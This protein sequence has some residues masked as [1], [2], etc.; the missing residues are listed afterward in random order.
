MAQNKYTVK[1]GGKTKTIVKKSPFKKKLL[2]KHKYLGRRLRENDAMYYSAAGVL[3]YRIRAKGQVEIFMGIEDMYDKVKKKWRKNQI[4][5]LGGKRER[6][7]MSPKNTGVREFWEESGGLLGP[8]QTTR[9]M[10]GLD[11]VLWFNGGKYA[12]YLYPVDSQ[13]AKY[14][15]Q[16]PSMYADA[17]KKGKL[18]GVTE[19]MKALGWFRLDLSDAQ[20][21]FKGVPRVGVV[22]SDIPKGFHISILTGSIFATPALKAYFRRVGGHG[23]GYDDA[24][25]G[26]GGAADL[27]TE[28]EKMG[29]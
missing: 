7:D 4:N 6:T 8:E 5:L 16:L 24:V 22:Q 17:R 10:R 13:D 14:F 15:D 12:V 23:S 11:T 20:K 21:S 25:A 19:E 26:G 27:A 9:M 3:P 2:T 18:E 1:L 28:F 29:M